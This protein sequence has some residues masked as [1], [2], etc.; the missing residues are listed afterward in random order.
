MK[1][2][3]VTLFI[4]I[5]ILLVMVIGIMFYLSQTEIVNLGG[6]SESNEDVRLF[7]EFVRECHEA[8]LHDLVYATSQQLYAFNFDLDYVEPNYPIFYDGS[9]R[10]P[11]ELEI[12]F[13]EF[14]TNEVAFCIGT[15]EGFSYN[16]SLNVEEVYA[17]MDGLVSTVH[18]K[19]DIV[20]QDFSW[21][22]EEDY[23]SE[24]EFDITQLFDISK[25]FVNAYIDAEGDIPVASVSAL[26]SEY[27]V[28]FSM[29][30]M[31][32]SQIITI[33]DPSYLTEGEPYEFVFVVYNY[34]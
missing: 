10:V 17:E 34:K 11:G 19:A 27:E 26:S 3:Q 13:A 6:A 14:V 7:E 24:L 22:P 15:Y 20:G 25:E 9:D 4:L 1:R 12:L 21:S 18:L 28:T 33:E 8:A 32:G 31:Q 30:P 23:E 29:Y 5:G 2:G 16:A